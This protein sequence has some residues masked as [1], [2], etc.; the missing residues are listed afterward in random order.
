MES[1][2]VYD[3][4][5]SAPLYYDNTT[6]G[7]SE[8]T[9]NVANLQVGQDWTKHGIKALTLHFY[10][11]PNNAVQQMYVKLNGSKVTY[12][13]D[14]EN[15]KALTWQMWYID[16]A[17]IGVSLSNVTELS[18]GFE[19][20]GAVGGQGVV[21]FDGI[22]LYSHDRQLITPV[23][24]GTANLVGHWM[25]DEGSGT[26]A[27]DSS[28]NNNH[29]TITGAEWVAGQ[30][31]GALNFKYGAEYV[32]VPPA[33]WSSVEK[34]VTIAFW[35]YGDPDVQPLSNFTVGAYQDPAVNNSRVFSAHVPWG[36]GIV[37]FD[38]GGTADGFDRI[39]KAATPVEYEGSWQHWTF[40]KDADTG[41]Q[42]IYLNGF[43]WHSGTDLTRPMTGV[44]AFTIGCKPG[45]SDYYVGMM[46]DVRLYDRALSEGEVAGLAGRTESFDKPF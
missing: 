15:L 24:P 5:Q 1:V 34:Q 20:S 18:I 14:A 23:E 42:S 13:G 39:S 29:G 3:G 45:P 30:V 26:T 27:A 35:A 9:V 33:A 31:G 6:A 43:L 2:T 4:E 40:T 11:D 22:R 7:Y 38:T 8:A 44:T 10:G 36:D 41:E 37:Y 25:F 16:L 17:S 19:R 21:Y 46:D 12:D 32:E 28:G